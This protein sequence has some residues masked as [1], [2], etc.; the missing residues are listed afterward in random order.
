[1]TDPQHPLES[2][3][4]RLRQVTMDVA[5]ALVKLDVG[6]CTGHGVIAGGDLTKL[7]QRLYA[8]VKDDPTLEGV[9]HA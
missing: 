4:H 5:I 6:L 2:E 9:P 8:E 7:A 3:L 1:M